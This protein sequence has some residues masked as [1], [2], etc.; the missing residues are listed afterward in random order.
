VKYTPHPGQRAFHDQRKTRFRVLACGARWGKDRASVNEFIGLC[1]TTT[2]TTDTLI[3][4]IHGW[5]VAPSFPL[6][7]QIWRELKAFTPP[8]IVVKAN[9]GTR[10]MELDNGAAI[11][12]KSAD[13]PDS[14]VAVGLDVL[15]ITEAALVSADAWDMAL[16]PRLASP[17]RAGLA[18]MN[19]TPKGRNWFYEAYLRGQDPEAPDWW[20]I[21]EPTT[22]NPHIDPA[23]VEKARREMPERWFRQEFLAEFLAGEGSVFRGVREAVRSQE[24]TG[25]VVVGV[26][27]AK[28]QDFT[29]LTALDE[30]GHVVGFDRFNQID[31]TLQLGRLQAFVA[32]V[33]ACFVLAEVNSIG[34]PLLERLK[35]ELPIPVDGFQTTGPSKQQIIEDLVLC[36]EQGHVTYPGNPQLI[37]ELEAYEYTMTKAGNTSYSAPARFHDDCVMSL[38]FANRARREHSRHSNQVAFL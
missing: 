30:E 36:I 18:I 15:L 13:N 27:W 28:H 19:G 25:R 5:I 22:K 11:E 31:Y 7:N 35:R 14:L 16:R 38:A 34:D 12:I 4:R 21:N 9:E 6:S 29:V 32:E 10:T 24:R 1:Y 3:P 20:S 33:D 37:N 8:E 26:D 17:G 2:P 23:E